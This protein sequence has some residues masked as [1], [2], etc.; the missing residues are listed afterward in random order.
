MPVCCLCGYTTSE[1]AFYHNLQGICCFGI[2]ITVFVL[3][4]KSNHTTG[5][6][7]SHKATKDSRV[8]ST[9]RQCNH[10]NRSLPTKGHYQDVIQKPLCI[11]SFSM[12]LCIR[13]EGAQDWAIFLIFAVKIFTPWGNV[14]STT[15]SS[16]PFCLQHFPCIVSTPSPKGG[17]IRAVK[18]AVN[19]PEQT[20]SKAAPFT[21]P[22]NTTC[23]PRQPSRTS[24][25]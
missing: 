25:Y 1:T 22:F 6:Y 4:F 2:T 15:T 9:R 20:H 7:V 11:H 13:R 19:M 10:E 18:P 21:T 14:Y 3:Y 12:S 23:P 8:F 16:C 17:I 24:L 5:F